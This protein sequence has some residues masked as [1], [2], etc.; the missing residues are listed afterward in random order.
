MKTL[1]DLRQ[2]LE[3]ID[4]SP[5]KNYKRLMGAYALENGLELYIDRVQS[6]PFA[7]PSQIRLRLPLAATGIPA[8]LHSKR[9]RRTALEDFIARATLRR[10]HKRGAKRLGSGHSGEINIDAGK[11]E[12]L[13]RSACRIANNYLEL[14]LEAGLPAAGRRVL[15]KQAL[16]ML[17]EGLPGL[18]ARCMMWEVMPQDVAR[19]FVETAENYAA[20]REQLVLKKLVG[21]VADQSSLPRRSG[22]DNRPLPFSKAVPFVSPETMRVTIKIPNATSER[23]GGGRTI[24]GMGIPEGITLI[25]GGGFHGKSTLLDALAHGVYP[26]IPGDGREY[27]VTDPSG[28]TIRAEDG[29]NVQAVDI[30]AFIRDLPGGR[31]TSHFSTPNASGST[32]QATNIIE[33]LEAGSQLLLIDEDSSATN[34][35]IRD[36][37]MQQ[38]IQ[39][40][41]EPITPLIDRIEGMYEHASCSTILVMGGCGD[42]FD[43]A[44]TVIAMHDYK[45]EVV[46]DQAREVA[47][48][49]PSRRTAEQV[50]EFLAPFARTIHACGL[51]PNRNGREKV[52]AKGVEHLKFGG[53][54]ID[55]R[56]VSQLR[57]ASQTRAVGRAMVLVS[58][59]KESWSK[60]LFKI[61]DDIEKLM[62]EKGIDALGPN[63]DSGAHPGNLSRPRRYEIAAALNRLRVD[64]LIS[65]QQGRG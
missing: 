39:R 57:E 14:R 61:L 31:D 3:S 41:R 59:N 23:F 1:E 24:T 56:W 6:D 30:S 37:R 32:S 64:K 7:H 28:V 43:V 26:H 65:Q 44:N 46:T 36:A 13:E 63:P 49:L 62:D 4:G 27:V 51:N 22:A 25:V 11:Q 18:A 12:V 20:I 17:L 2:Q 42:Y 58:Q 16:K 35:M 48:N 21:F 10:L 19:E 54:D 47:A 8:G 40:D 60:R 55:L 53:T 50:D 9:V 29:R 45:P 15:A 38:L 34:F 5:Y 33:A 52:D